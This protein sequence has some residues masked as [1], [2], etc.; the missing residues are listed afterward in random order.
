[1]VVTGVAPVDYK[2]PLAWAKG[3][4]HAVDRL[5]EDCAAD[6]GCHKSIPK[7]REDFAAVLARL[8]KGPV[9][10]D[11]PNPVTQ[12]MQTVQLSRATFNEH[13][14]GLLYSPDFASVLPL[15]IHAAAQGNFQ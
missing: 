5:F 1:M 14:R 12:Q 15:I 13:L 4:Q 3:V 2:L 7:L 9:S 10:F 11:L 8:D 6:V